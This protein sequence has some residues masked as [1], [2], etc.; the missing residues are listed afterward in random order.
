MQVGRLFSNQGLH[1][2]DR[3]RT[4]AGKVVD[5]DECDIVW[6][7]FTVYGRGDSFCHGE[8]ELRFAAILAD[9]SRNM[10]DQREGIAGTVHRQVDA[11]WMA[12]SA[13]VG[14]SE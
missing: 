2:T 4:G 9:L 8:C 3:L 14:T 5:R 6:C 12:V 10:S 13:A 11:S 1:D 7:L